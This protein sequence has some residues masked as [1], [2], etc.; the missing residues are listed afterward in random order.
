[1]P[2]KTN[3]TVS[4][5]RKVRLA[6]VIASVLILMIVVVAVA[7]ERAGGLGS[8]DSGELCSTHP[9]FQTMGRGKGTMEFWS[10]VCSWEISRTPCKGLI[11]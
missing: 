2:D 1:M 11:R 6:A 3:S 10:R 5:L 4:R 9:S 8:G 7:I